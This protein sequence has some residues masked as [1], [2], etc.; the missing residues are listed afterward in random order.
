MGKKVIRFT[1]MLISI[2][3]TACGFALRSRL[4]AAAWAIVALGGALTL[5]SLIAFLAT[6][7]GRGKPPQK[8]MPEYRRKKTILTPAEVDFLAVLRSV[9]D[10]GRFEVIMQV[11]LVAV[12]DKLTQN[13]YRNELFRVVDFAL[14]DAV[15]FAPV[16]LI[17]L[18]DASHK[19]ADRAERDRKVSEICERAKMPLVMF[20]MQQA[21]DKAY[22]KKQVYRLMAHR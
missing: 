2:A 8:E 14:I 6:L 13:S 3:V 20:D 1:Q 21:T 11:P 10:L 17:E 5:I 19:R 15:T 9:V 7:I 16:L 18:N 22:V 12:I 4:G